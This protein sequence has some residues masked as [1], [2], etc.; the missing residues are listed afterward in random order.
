MKFRYEVGIKLF[1]TQK[2]KEDLDKA[3][4]AEETTLSAFIREAIKEKLK[5]VEG[6]IV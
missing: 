1:I 5:K 2:M 3:I 4:E 6:Q